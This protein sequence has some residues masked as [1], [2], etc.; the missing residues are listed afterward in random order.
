LTSLGGFLTVAP[1]MKSSLL[2]VAAL[3]LALS[4]CGLLQRQPL[5]LVTDRAELASYVEYVNAQKADLRVILRYREKPAEALRRNEGADLVLAE[6]LSG[7]AAGRSLDSLEDLFRSGRLRRSDFYAP[8]LAS[9]AP[10]RRQ[11]LIPLSFSIPAVLFLPYSLREAAP[12]LSLSLDYLKDQGGQYNQS[13][14]GSLVRLGFSPLWDNAFLFIAAELQGANFHMDAGGGLGW[15][16]KGLQEAVAYLKNWVA[17][18]NGGAEA[19]E[20]FRAKYLYQPLGRLL[21]EK[22]IQFYL[23]TSRQLLP[24]LEDHKEEA[25]FRWLAGPEKIYVD[26]D[27]LFAGVPRSS[28]RKKAAREFLAWLF[29]PEIQKRL[30][31]AS[32]R[33]RLG[34]FGIAGGFS[35]LKSVNEREFPLY[36]SRLIGRIPPEELLFVPGP[37]PPAWDQIKNQVLLPWL[38]EAAVSSA[39]AEELSTR[40]QAFKSGR[41]R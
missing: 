2:P 11:V 25:D 26:E 5:V 41:L 27:I 13:V 38:R 37:L 28:G 40:L 36:Y 7:Y 16:E 21:D 12:N 19:E 3:A 1:D 33:Q 23:T 34:F 15:N 31:E 24:A 35:S 22:R 32:R 9:G 10:E 18:T 14:R 30:L 39:S 17:T 6:G 4:G 29:Q 20:A 8:I